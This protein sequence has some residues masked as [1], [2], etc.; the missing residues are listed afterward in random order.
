MKIVDVC[1]FLSPHGGGVKTYIEQKLLLG[2]RLGHEIVIIAPGDRDELIDR[3]P[4]AKIVKLASPRFPLDRK[5][6]YFDDEARLH[7][8]LDAEA[9]DFVEASSPWR[10]ASMVGRWAPDVP[11]ALVM[12]ADPLSAYAYRWFGGLMKRATIDRRF[13]RY[14]E[15]LREL[16]Q[17]FDM[18]VCA[19]GELQER[20]FAGGI[21]HAVLHPMGIEAKL[22]SP[23]RRD[24]ALRRQMLELCDLPEEAHLL[25][26]VGRLSAEKRWPMVIDAVA[27]ASRNLP[28]GLVMLGAGGQKRR[29]LS[30]I[31]GNP[32]I[33]L[34]A[35]ERNREKFAALLA[36]ADAMI[37]GCEAETFCMA[38]A[39]ARAAG[40][41][42]IVPDRG[43]A[44]D[45]ARGGAGIAYKAGNA[46]AASEAIGEL[47]AGRIPVIGT[48]MPPVT[49]EEHFVRLFEAYETL[50]L[51]QP[52][53][54]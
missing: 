14:W 53:A 22:F 30:Q 10:S 6:W 42:V 43:G 45:H 23:E 9:P 20:M 32:H 1:A 31:A 36:S 27:A 33:R 2:P 35:P 17:A 51:R 50:R 28:I 21:S 29:I 16:N 11:K 41:P 24:L 37:H 7:A 39:E 13:E 5:Y 15:H 34:L 40:V 19:S 12:H 8:A 18:V 3:G 54:A 49:M 47:F 38:A 25:I 52:V 46:L 48:A 4:G 26:A 44:S